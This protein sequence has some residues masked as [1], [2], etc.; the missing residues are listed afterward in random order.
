MGKREIKEE[1]NNKRS[2][3]NTT[4][5]SELLNSYRNSLY[6]IKGF[7]D[8]ASRDL[9]DIDDI[10]LQLKISQGIITLGK[11]IGAN[12]ES[13]DKLEDKVKREEKES[14]IIKGGREASLF[15][16]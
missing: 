1:V 16:E 9:V 7:L 11:S 12:I 8:R 2:K 10:E 6:A 15:E 14:I 3:A 13:L 5:S 4:I